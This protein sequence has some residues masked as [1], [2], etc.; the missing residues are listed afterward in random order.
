LNRRITQ[1]K[2]I[3]HNMDNEEICQKDD[4]LLNRTVKS[5]I[6]VGRIAGQE[7]RQKNIKK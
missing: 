3:S 7:E 2:V 4:R 6:E 5:L 1:E